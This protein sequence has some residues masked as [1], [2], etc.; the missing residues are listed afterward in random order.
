M[1]LRFQVQHGLPLGLPRIFRNR[2]GCAHV[3]VRWEQSA[4]AKQHKGGEVQVAPTLVNIS[5]IF[6]LA[7]ADISKNSSFCA[8]AYSWTSCVWDR[9]LVR[10]AAG[11]NGAEGHTALASFGIA[12]LTSR[13]SLFPASAITISG[14]PF[15]LN[16]RTLTSDRELE[17]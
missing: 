17:S 12:R 11:K 14:V 15:C 10:Y 2:L 9:D 16:S 4:P 3:R 6:K 5:W 1:R 8:S 7:F 13:S